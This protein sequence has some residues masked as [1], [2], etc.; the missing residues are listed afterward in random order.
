MTIELK[1]LQIERLKAFAIEIISKMFDEG[2]SLDESDI[3]EIAIKYKLIK[4]EFA[5][6]WWSDEHGCDHWYTL[7]SFL[8]DKK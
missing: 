1:L 3:Q 2:D 6:G 8:K 4:K 5:P 7:A